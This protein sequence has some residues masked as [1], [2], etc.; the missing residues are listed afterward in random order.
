MENWTPESGFCWK[1]HRR[2]ALFLKINKS[3]ET[4]GSSYFTRRWRRPKGGAEMG[5]GGPSSPLGVVGPPCR[6]ERWFGGPSPPQP[7]PLR[8]LDPLGTLTQGGGPS[9]YSATST[10]RKTPESEKLPCR[11]KSARGN[12]LP[13]G[14]I[15][16]IITVIELDFIGIIIIIISTANTIITAAAPR[17]RYNI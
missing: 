2:D 10:R 14:E 13:E 9:K 7:F 11:K 5:H 3:K 16:A 12:S 15:I 1:K 17:L 6:A 4:Y 8:V